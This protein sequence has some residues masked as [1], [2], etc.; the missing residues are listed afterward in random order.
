[1]CSGDLYQVKD[2]V[3]TLKNIDSSIVYGGRSA[4]K[5]PVQVQVAPDTDE[6]WWSSPGKEKLSSAIADTVKDNDVSTSGDES[7]LADSP[8]LTEDGK[9]KKR[10]RVEPV[11]EDELPQKK[12]TK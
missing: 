3:V 8:K 1:M 12:R 4:A 11:I 10:T 7:N 5:E 6:D 2:N 9:G